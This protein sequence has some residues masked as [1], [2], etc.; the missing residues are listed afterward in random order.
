MKGCLDRAERRVFK[1][2]LSDYRQTND[3]ETLV[4]GLQPLLDRADR[5]VLLDG[6]RQFVRPQKRAIFDASIQACFGTLHHAPERVAVCLLTGAAEPGSDGKHGPAAPAAAGD[7]AE[8]VVHASVAKRHCASQTA[9]RAVAGAPAASS[10]DACPVCS[11]R[12]RQPFSSR[13][14]HALCWLCWIG[15][16]AAAEPACPVCRWPVRRRHLT[17]LYMR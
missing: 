6:L 10:A 8:T 12:L 11:Q 2:L 17:K 14:G 4:R 1:Q 3:V 7:A 5:I 13:C 9:E 16:L 15:V